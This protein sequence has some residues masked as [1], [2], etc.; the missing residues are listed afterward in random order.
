MSISRPS[1]GAEVY[2]LWIGERRNLA[3]PNT[4]RTRRWHALR[5]NPAPWHALKEFQAGVGAGGFIL[6]GADPCDTSLKLDASQG[7][8]S[9]NIPILI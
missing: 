3:A 8:A 7:C 9:S 5:A 4:F 1:G 6:N 2:F